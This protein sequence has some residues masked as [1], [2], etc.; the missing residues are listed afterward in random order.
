MYIVLHRICMRR[1]LGGSERWVTSVGWLAL[2]VAAFV[3]LPSLLA[4]PAPRVQGL[5]SSHQLTGWIPTTVRMGARPDTSGLTVV[6]SI[7]PNPAVAGQTIWFNTSVSPGLP[8]YS[9][10]WNN[11]PSPCTKPPT[12]V[13]NFTCVARG[14]SQTNVTVFVMDSTSPTPLSG[15]QS[16]QLHVTSALTV[17]LDIAP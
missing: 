5:A 15:S 10:H 12:N 13:G 8:P 2:A 4:P 1:G 17:G 16:D 14:Y 6:L 11:L 3:L 9:Y 7:Q